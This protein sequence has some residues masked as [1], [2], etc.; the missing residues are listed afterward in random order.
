VGDAQVIFLMLLSLAYQR[1]A[2]GPLLAGLPVAAR[3]L[4]DAVARRLEGLADSTRGGGKR[5]LAD[6][7]AALATVEAALAESPREMS[8]HEA[9]FAIQQRLQLYKTLVRLV[10]QLDPWLADR[11]GVQAASRR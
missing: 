4:E 11:S 2:P 5:P 3:Q 1:R 9:V 8:S 7:D 6:L 10:S